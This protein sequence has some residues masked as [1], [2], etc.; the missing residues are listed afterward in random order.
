[1]SIVIQN[2]LSNLPKELQEII[3]EYAR[4][5]SKKKEMIKDFTFMYRCLTAFCWGTDFGMTD[6]YKRFGKGK[7]GW[8]KKIVLAKESSVVRI[9]QKFSTIIITT[10]YTRIYSLYGF[11]RYLEE[12]DN[13]FHVE[14]LIRKYESDEEKY[15][16]YMREARFDMQFERI[17]INGESYLLMKETTTD[18]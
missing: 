18:E 4:D 7:Y 15:D 10:E 3:Y 12:K 17:N 8:M 2:R 13:K 16:Y 9:E 6:S 11:I 1:M 5:D 14:C